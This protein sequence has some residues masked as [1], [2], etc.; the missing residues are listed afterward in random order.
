MRAGTSRVPSKA[1]HGPS[2]GARRHIEDEDENEDEDDS[3][4]QN[5]RDGRSRPFRR[6]STGYCRSLRIV[7]GAALACASMAVPACKR[8][9]FFVKLTISSDMSVSAICDS[10]AVRF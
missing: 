7:C 10:E 4:L 3:A 2:F 6:S 8:I 9:W 1:V 5:K